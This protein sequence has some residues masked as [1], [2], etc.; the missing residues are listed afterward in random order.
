MITGCAR[1]VEN[2]KEQPRGADRS[3]RLVGDYKD[4]NVSEKVLGIIVSYTDYVKR[5]GWHEN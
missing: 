5:Y 1:G 2:L 3:F 4:P